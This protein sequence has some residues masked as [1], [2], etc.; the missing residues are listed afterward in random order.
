MNQTFDLTSKISQRSLVTPPS[1]IRS[2]LKAK[3][4]ADEFIN[5][6]FTFNTNPEFSPIIEELQKIDNLS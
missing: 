2:I 5:I 1:F 3:E 4:D 6:L